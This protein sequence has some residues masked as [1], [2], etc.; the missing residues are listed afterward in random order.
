MGSECTGRVISELGGVS[1]WR[2]SP[3]QG[4]RHSRFSFD[5][6]LRRSGAVPWGLAPVVRLRRQPRPGA[7]PGGAS[8]ARSAPLNKEVITACIHTTKKFGLP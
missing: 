1:D 2:R 8:A 4:Q 3:R 5:S 7:C 6:I